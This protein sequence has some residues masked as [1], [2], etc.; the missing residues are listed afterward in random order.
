MLSPRNSVTVVEGIES[1]PPTP[2]IH[3][4]QLNPPISRQILEGN[5]ESK[6]N[7]LSRQI[8]NWKL[9]LKTLEEEHFKLMGY[10]PSR[11]DRANHKEMRKCVIHINRA[12]HDLKRKL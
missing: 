11:A 7:I 5:Q 3:Q 10:K 12:K 6:I 8:T 9:Q 2:P 1:I 4:L